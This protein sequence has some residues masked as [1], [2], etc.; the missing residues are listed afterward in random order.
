MEA[1][2]LAVGSRL[3]ATTDGAGRFRFAT[4]APGVYDITATLP[5]FRAARFEHVE[6][7]LGQIKQLDFTLLLGTVTET[8]NASSTPPLLD[9]KQSARGSSLRQDELAYLPRGRDYASVVQLFPGTNLEPKLGGISVDG[10]SAAENRFLIDGVDTTHAVSG[11]QGQSL[12]LANVEEV[13]I[14][15]SGY[16]AEY[17]GSTGGIIS[18]L[19]K[20]GT[21]AWHGDASV[22]FTG[23]ALDAGPRPT[24]QRNAL[25]SSQ[26]EYATYPKD[27]Y[28]ATEPGFSVGGPISRDRAWF[29]L[30]YQPLLQH[31]ERT[32]TF[33][34]D[35]SSATSV[36]DVTRHL[37]TAS[38]TLQLGSRLR[39]R[40]SFNYA[41]TRTDGLLPALTG[42]DSPVSNFGVVSHE[43]TGR[44]R[45]RSTS[46]PAPDFCCPAAPAT[47]GRT[48]TRITSGPLRRTR[49]KCPMSASSTCRRRCSA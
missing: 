7:L 46:W 40:A 43:P 10:S 11:L 44:R 17:G 2:H 37:L 34:V 47:P 25:D 6:I 29:F 33:A 5:G 12:N 4:L 31:T 9:V 15:S 42:T 22:Y 21:N 45:E 16:A 32:V 1:R 20:S 36:Q 39:T 38:Q 23:S 14:K 18:V 19:T 48:F 49:S 8:V 30:A 27:S 3:D 28:H 35:G 24:L 41:P 13:Q 26:A